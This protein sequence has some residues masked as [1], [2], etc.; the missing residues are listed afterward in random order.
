MATIYG[1]AGFGDKDAEEAAKSFKK[2]MKGIG[3]DEK[4]IIKE[5]LAFSNAQ[6]QVIKDKY[7]NMYGKT[8]EEDLKSELN[9]NFEN[10]VIALLKPRFVY[11]AECMNKAMKVNF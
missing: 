5:M 1:K 3:T 7:Y 6:R 11:E 10:I 2:A 8:L 9:G 4:R